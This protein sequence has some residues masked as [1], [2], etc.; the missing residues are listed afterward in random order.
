MKMEDT[1]K[2][3]P[4]AGTSYFGG[5]SGSGTYQK[6]INQIPP[7]DTFI[8]GFLGKCG[9]LRN[10]RPAKFNFGVDIDPKVIEFWECDDRLKLVNE[11]FMETIEIFRQVAC[12]TF[13]YL[14]PPYPLSARRSRKKV[15]NYEMTDE[16]H[17]D[18]LKYIKKM[19]CM[20]A[21][22]TYPNSLYQTMLRDWRSISFDS[23]TRQGKA[24]ELLYM[25]YPEPKELHDYRYIGDDFRERE[26]IKK[27]NRSLRRKIKNLDQLER[28]KL[29]NQL[30]EEYKI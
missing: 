15:Y 4:M 22:S 10:K 8:S 30:R 24:T 6:I 14:D 12:I 28:N 11:S 9:I 29:F 5:K 1:F 21:I 26:L 25:N 3:K 27:R 18:L 16:E 19:R 7:H 13:I 17:I 2:L 20:I 23:Q